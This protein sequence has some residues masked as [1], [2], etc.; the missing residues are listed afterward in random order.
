MTFTAK[1]CSPNLRLKWNLIVLAAVVAND[2][3]ALG[4]VIALPRFF[5]PTLCAP[6]R[7]H[8]VSLVKDLLFFFGEKEGL[9]TLNASSLDV[10]HIRFSL[11]CKHRG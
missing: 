10:R 7:R 8:H 9:F 6:L 11:Y 1:D 3:E 2:L 5:G 4:C